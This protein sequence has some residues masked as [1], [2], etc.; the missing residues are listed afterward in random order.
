MPALSGFALPVT[1]QL[2][3]GNGQ[4]FEATMSAPNVNTQQI[5]KAKGD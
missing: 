4:C 1:T 3:S 5:F 2:Q